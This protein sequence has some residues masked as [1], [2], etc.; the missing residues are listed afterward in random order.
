[1]YQ[2]DQTS[3]QD[4]VSVCGLEY[5]QKSETFEVRVTGYFFLLTS[6]SHI[7]IGVIWSGNLAIY[8]AENEFLRK[9]YL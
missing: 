7:R 6:N 4:P 1:E 9:L 2:S 5:I 3:P 8:Q